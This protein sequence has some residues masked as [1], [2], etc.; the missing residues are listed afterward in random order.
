MD[1]F[2][3]F[4][5]E[6]HD[7]KTVVVTPGGNHGDTLIH[8]G[9]VKKLDEYSVNYSCLNLEHLYEGNPILGAKYLINIALRK[10]GSDM[11]FRLLDIPDDTELILFEGGGYMSDIWYGPVLLRQV[12]KRHHAPVAV[13][14]QSYLFTK[15]KFSDY[16]KDGRQ[17]SLFCREA[18][19]KRHLDGLGL[20]SNVSVEVSPELA[21]YLTQGDL[22][23]YINPSDDGHVLV[24]FR[25]DK[26]SA[27]T[28]EIK[29]EYL[30]MHANVVVKDVSMTGTLTDF[31]SSVANAEKIYTDRLHVAILS[32]IL[33]KEVTLFGNKYHKNKGVWE[34]SLK[35]MVF[36]I[37]A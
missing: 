11:G 5:D 10:L 16:F 21:L 30:T 23:K 15:T 3:Q 25:E 6:N 28:M 13:G 9:L 8:W 14:P 7:R 31:V 36:F 24:A 29:N 33:G 4:L 19:S 18:Y 34:L 1:A 22:E 12:M 20:P 35:D 32:V 37:E 27:V 2:E 26:E 17:V